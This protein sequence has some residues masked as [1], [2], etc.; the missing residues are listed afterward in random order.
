[1]TKK[2]HQLYDTMNATLNN[3]DAKLDVLFVSETQ[4]WPLDQGFRIRGSHMS[5][6]L[7][8]KGLRVGCACMNCD[9]PA[10]VP[11]N[12]RD[13]QLMWPKAN[14]SQLAA[15]MRAW[16]GAGSWLRQK[17]AS[18]QGVDVDAMAGVRALVE[19]HQPR[20]VVALGQHGPMMLRGL[21]DLDCQRIWYAADEPLRFQMSCMVKEPWSRWPERLRQIL[22]YGGLEAA[23]VR[24]MDGAIGVSPLDAKLLRWVGGAKRVAMIRNGV[25]LDYFKPATTAASDKK[26]NPRS[27]VFWGRLDFEPNIDAVQWFAREVWPVLLKHQPDATWTIVG[28]F[29]HASVLEIAKLP[30]VSLKQ[31]VPDIRPFAQNAALTIL[32]MRCGGGIKNKLLEAAAMALPVVVS[33]RAVQGLGLPANEMPVHV[34]QNPQAWVDDILH[35][36]LHTQARQSLGERAHQWVSEQHS[37]SRAASDFCQWLHLDTTDQL[38]Q[39]LLELQSSQDTYREAA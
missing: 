3:P 34:C 8:A 25:D 19:T 14:T 24:N 1:M 27:V 16:S 28:K 32:P 35:L 2:L 33:P 22:F 13:R 12:M 7:A 31:N 18:H 37:W 9:D 21:N 23:F 17:I 10:S 30:G 26:E 39:P 4:L 20:V 11:Q 6:A 29:P 5:M 38:D 36:W 15:F